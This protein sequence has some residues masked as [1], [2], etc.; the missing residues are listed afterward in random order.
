MA[1]AGG[2]PLPLVSVGVAAAREGGGGA[3]GLGGIGVLVTVGEGT[4]STVNGPV[5]RVLSLFTK[6]WSY[7]NSSFADSSYAIELNVICGTVLYLKPFLIPSLES[8]NS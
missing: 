5:I 3:V 7:R 4:A 1:S 6:G 8:F 2:F